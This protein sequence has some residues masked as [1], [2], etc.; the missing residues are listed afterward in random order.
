MV[1]RT[2]IT[3]RGAMQGAGALAAALAAPAILPGKAS[4]Q[5][6]DRVIIGMTQEPV[7]FNPLLYVNAGTENVPEACMFDAL[8]DMNDEGKFIPNLATA[9]P[10]RE[11]G[12]ISA[13][14]KTWKINL[15]RGVKWSDGAPFTAKDV[16]FTYQAIINPKVAI[17]SRSGFD[18]ID[19]FKVVDDHSIEIQLTRPFVPFLWAWQNMHIVPQHLLSKEADLNTSGYNSQP[20]GTGPYTLKTRV[21]GSHMIYERNPNY[22]RGPAKIGTVIH[23]FVP[24]QL[25]LYSQARTGEVDYMGL[26]GV[27]YDRFEEAKK[28]ADREFFAVPQPWVQFIYFN[29]GK[30]QFKDPK[31]R[32]ALYIATEMQKSLDDIYFGAWKRTMSYL[33]T[34]H[35]AYNPNLKDPTPNPELAAKMLDEAGWKVGADGIREKDGVKMKFTCSTTAG[36]PARQ[37]CQALFQQN[38]K[39]IGVD[40]EIK[41][42]PAS[43]V[44][45]EYTTK[46]QFD[47]LLVAWEPTVGMDPDYSARAHS[48]QIPV[49]SG[50]GSNYVQYENAEVDKLLEQGVNETDTEARK[51]IYW[52][53]QEILHEEVPFAPQ[54][55]T[56]QG[57]LK[58][59]NLLNDKPN[60]YV[61]DATWNVQD[62]SWA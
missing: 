39:K 37:G 59:K 58:R 13:D 16:E 53:V 3:R 52:R 7:Q 31:V 50:S 15:K 35:W 51:K 61:T 23:K 26:T 32:R 33:H 57:R 56:A 2:R 10:S 11:D 27:P 30:P 5:S 29:C 44:W 8:W 46:S 60:Q 22:H 48:K 14:G 1:S 45:G 4:A 25:V 40:M 49:K 24:D 54:A 18:L 55:G 6:K 41:N 17:R 9:I 62:W 47:T 12:S 36:V 21:A 34:S 28:I 20:V 38:W 43:V 42:M 19:K